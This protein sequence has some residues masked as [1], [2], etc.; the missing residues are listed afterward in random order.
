[1]ILVIGGTGF[2]GQALT[3]SLVLMGKPVRLLLRPSSSSP[4]LPRGNSLEVAI[5]SL[6]DE[7]GLLA[8]MKN[9]R[10]I[11]HLAGTER[12]GSRADL[13]GVDIEGTTALV[14]AATIA[15]VE[16]FIYLSHL[17]ADPHSA[18]SLLR[19]KG[20]AE[21]AIRQSGL[22]YTIFHSSVIYG[23]GDQFTTLLLKLIRL[24]PFFFLLPGEGNMLLQPIWLE[25][26][27]AC[28]TWLLMEEQAPAQVYS[29]GGAEYLSFRQVIEMIMK[30]S[31]IKRAILP[32]PPQYLRMLSIFMAQVFPRFPLSAFWMDYLATDRTCSLDTLPR[33]FG[34]MPARF[35]Q[36]ISYLKKS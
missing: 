21:A 12:A 6:T 9:V 26:L 28:M 15:G 24:S 2:V 7:R 14:R 35:H 1:M 33:V 8:A 11:Y 16:R 3:R 36:S 10:I 31:G 22:N 25:D 13:N 32:F 4:N 30:T 34:I 19:A 18:F 27:V 20:L 17:D 5:S 29:I 23:P